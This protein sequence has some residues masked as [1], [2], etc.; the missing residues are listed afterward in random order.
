MTQI[1]SGN[2]VFI[3]SGNQFASY[4]PGKI[5]VNNG[6]DLNYDYNFTEQPK[7]MFDITAVSIL[8]L[9]KNAPAISNG[10][11]TYGYKAPGNNL[12]YGDFVVLSN[13]ANPSYNV[14]L[15][16]MYADYQNTG[17]DPFVGCET[18][19]PPPINTCVQSAGV[20][21]QTVNCTAN[22]MYGM[23]VL[24]DATDGFGYF[25][26]DHIQNFGPAPQNVNT[27]AQ[28]PCCTSNPDNTCP[29]WNGTKRLVMEGDAIWFQNVGNQLCSAGNQN[30]YLSKD[31]DNALTWIS[32]A[33]PYPNADDTL[34]TGF[35]LLNECT[36]SNGICALPCEI[37][38]S[39]DLAPIKS[40]YYISIFNE[41]NSYKVIYDSGNYGFDD[42]IGTNLRGSKTS[43]FLIKKLIPGSSLN[44]QD[45]FYESDDPDST[46][47]A[48]DLFVLYGQNTNKQVGLV[49]TDSEVNNIDLNVN[50][51]V[52]D[53][54]NGCGI[55]GS[56]FSQWAF[57][58]TDGTGN[59]SENVTG[60]PVVFGKS[61][62]IQNLGMNK[63]FSINQLATLGATESCFWQTSQGATTNTPN[64][65][66]D[67]L[68]DDYPGKNGEL[69]D[70]YQFYMLTG[71]GATFIK[72]PPG[73]CPVNDCLNC[74]G[75]DTSNANGS[76][77]CAI[78]WSLGSKLGNLFT[79]ILIIFA[80]I[81]G[82]IIA[83]VIIVVIISAISHAAKK[84]K[85][86]SDHKD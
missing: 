78:P 61:Y 65:N 77:G 44:G 40:G 15:G 72:C 13:Y 32:I 37:P 60:A 58:E 82:I 11:T 62:F 33:N 41:V 57:V 30:V 71:Q 50:M 42:N 18:K 83:I 3:M 47:N 12:Y 76:C 49:G 14:P 54:D 55:S 70:D 24:V 34:T 66:Y 39:V 26:D 36:A 64:L 75:G 8:S 80:V 5:N 1:L 48:G 53:G 69:T 19:K 23:W 79:D 38:T 86:S 84:P 43:T 35:L 29:I 28:I 51:Q 4:N 81:F 9:G 16:W 27:N 45:Q 74:I 25:C 67:F 7:Q 73:G 22:P 68:T 20:S 56:F 10:N 85:E 31:S 59:L 17:K 46:I 63:C 21:S 6:G 2:A 52:V